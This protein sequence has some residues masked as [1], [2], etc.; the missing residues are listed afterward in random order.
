MGAR[1]LRLFSYSRH[2][3][4]EHLFPLYLMAGDAFDIAGLAI[5]FLAGASSQD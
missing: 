5:K 4:D 3:S 1:K 2:N